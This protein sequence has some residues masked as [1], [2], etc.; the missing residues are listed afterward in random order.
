MERRPWRGPFPVTWRGCVPLLSACSLR[1]ASDTC[2]RAARQRMDGFYN[3]CCRPIRPAWHAVKRHLKRRSRRPA[4]PR[5]VAAERVREAG[6]QAP[7]GLL[8]DA[9]NCEL[10]CQVVP[11]P[12]A[13]RETEKLPSDGRCRSRG[14][15]LR[16]QVPSTARKP[17]CPARV[18]PTRLRVH[19]NY[20][21]PLRSHRPRLQSHAVDAAKLQHRGRWRGER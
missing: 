3:P 10:T 21:K 14:T 4:P 2:R 6:R 15:A 7:Q 5:G 19:R 20:A 8:K 9:A 18:G 17:K 12:S 16:A 11:G 13:G 1:F